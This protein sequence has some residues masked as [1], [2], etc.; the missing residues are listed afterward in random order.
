[1]VEHS[2]DRGRWDLCELEA[3]LLYCASS[4]TVREEALI[5]GEAEPS[6]CRDVS[7]SLVVASFSIPTLTW[8][9]SLYNGCTHVFRT[10][11][12]S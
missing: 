9:A 12:F 8:G 7:L 3:S 11:C 1:M 4:R 2:G 10:Y 5:Q 6:Q